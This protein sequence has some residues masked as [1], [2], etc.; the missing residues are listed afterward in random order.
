MNPEHT[1]IAGER[2]EDLEAALDYLTFEAE[3]CGCI[4]AHVDHAIPTEL[5]RC[6][7]RALK[8]IDAELEEQGLCACID[9]KYQPLGQ[10]MVRIGEI[11]NRPE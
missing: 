5:Q 9:E 2:I 3:D 10:L 4:N 1:T 11:R 6:L 8:A 7:S